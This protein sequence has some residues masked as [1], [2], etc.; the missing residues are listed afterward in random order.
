[1]FSYADDEGVISITILR[2]SHAGIEITQFNES[3]KEENSEIVIAC[4]IMDPDAFRAMI[5]WGQ[6]KA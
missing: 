5:A 2:K 4:V 6:G 1:M 3:E